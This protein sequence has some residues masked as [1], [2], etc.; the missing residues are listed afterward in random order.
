MAKT[1]PFILTANY[2]YTATDGTCKTMRGKAKVTSVQSVSPGSSES[3][4]IAA[5]TKFGPIALGLSA[6]KSFMQYKTGIYND[7]TCVG[8]CGGHAVTAVGWGQANGQKFYI[9]R[10]SWGAGWGESGYVRMATGGEGSK[11]VCNI[12]SGGQWPSLVLA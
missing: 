1:S 3:A 5:I 7:K 11:G 10:N 4:M 8:P 9:V 2:P 6:C 12:Q